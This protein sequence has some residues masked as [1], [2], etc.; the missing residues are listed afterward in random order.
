MKYRSLICTLSLLLFDTA[1]LYDLEIVVKQSTIPN[2]GYGAFL[3]FLGARRRTKNAPTRGLCQST[4][5]S[6][7]N[8]MEKETATVSSERLQRA[9]SDFGHAGD[10]STLLPRCGGANSD[11][12]ADYE[13]DPEVSFGTPKSLFVNLGVYGPLRKQDLVPE[14][15]YTM[16]NFIFSDGPAEYAF[17]SHETIHGCAQVVDITDNF[18]LV[19]EI[20][21]QN[22]PM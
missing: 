9:S 5:D 22:V 19:H 21:R 6:F 7:R 17:G 13:S 18:G 14:D 2:G 11:A 8:T 12:E 4:L 20:A 16:K 1:I 15:V 3:K 10:S